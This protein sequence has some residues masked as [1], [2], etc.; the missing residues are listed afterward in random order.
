VIFL[1]VLPVVPITAMTPVCMLII[2][3]S[4]KG[5]ACPALHAPAIATIYATLRGRFSS[6][7]WRRFE[8]N[9]CSA[10]SSVSSSALRKFSIAA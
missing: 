7:S 1:P 4:P 5:Y 9:N 8:R 10:V 2:L 6:K 3:A